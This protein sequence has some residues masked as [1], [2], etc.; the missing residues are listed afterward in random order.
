MRLKRLILFPALLGFTCAA[1]RQGDNGFKLIE[2]TSRS[3]TAAEVLYKADAH[4][5]IPASSQQFNPGFT[6]SVF[7]ILLQ[8]DSTTVPAA[9]RLVIGNVHINR[10]DFYQVINGKPL[11]SYLTGDHFPFRTRPV[12]STEFCFPLS[13]ESRVYLVRVDK[14][15][16]SLQLTYRLTGS[17]QFAESTTT[18]LVITGVFT[19]MIL[20]LLVFGLYM[21]VLTRQRMY[22]LYIAYLAAGWLWVLSDL[23]YGFKYLWPENPWFASRARPFF[24]QLTLI[25]SVQY[26]VYFVGGL[27]SLRMRKILNALSILALV[28][29]STALL[30]VD[31]AKYPSLYLFLLKLIP[32]TSLVYVILGLS[33]L[34]VEIY[35][36]NRM[37]LFYLGALIPLMLMVSVNALNHAGMINITGTSL[38]QFGVPAGYLC[39]AVIL[40]FG[41]VIQFNSYRLEKNRIQEAY[42]LQRRQAISAV[43]ET[44]TNERKRIGDEL[45]DIAGS[46]LSAA[47][48]NISSLQEKNI[49]GDDDAR[50]KLET[51]EQ[52]IAKVSDT[53]RS[54]SHAISPAALQLTGFKTA[55]SNIAGYFNAAGKL[56]F[57]VSMIGFE[58]HEP[59]LEPLYTT[60]YNIVFELMNNTAKHSGASEAFIQLVRHPDSVTLLAEDNGKG[61]ERPGLQATRGLNSVR[62]R[63]AHF[64]GNLSIDNTT[65]GLVISI[66]IP[67]TDYATKNSTG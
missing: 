15:F 3:L 28:F 26:L 46:M 29:A 51:A 41:M 4:P 37:A 24:S 59:A 9:N 48:M 20:L 40:C 25:L 11:R 55:V 57:E 35:R 43:I 13:N 38:E 31:L 19:G 23:G 52:A 62:N 32:A 66:E 63:V 49:I 21:S 8:L 39:E 27:A 2:D 65:T 54:L 61:M 7:W 67:V 1:A 18:R 60:L 53:V 36:N 34:V 10:L 56:R 5:F 47:R 22:L 58:I 50:R 42:E 64:N 6:R 12:A 45:H 44:E 33:A 16:E 14:S 30:P 17:E